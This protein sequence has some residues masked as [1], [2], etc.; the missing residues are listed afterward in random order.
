MI[1]KIITAEEAKKK[2]T[3][4]DNIETQRREKKQKREVKKIIK[5]IRKKIDDAIFQGNFCAIY[6]HPSY[7]VS[8]SHKEIEDVFTSLGYKVEI[9]Q[10]FN[11]VSHDTR[12]IIRWGDEND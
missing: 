4:F 10:E 2:S 12:F 9:K 6:H 7:I 8:T 11:F 3:I 5:N 1:K